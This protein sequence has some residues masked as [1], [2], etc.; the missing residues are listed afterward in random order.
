MKET[1]R[2]T[3]LPKP[4]G[5]YLLTIPSGTNGPV[6]VSNGDPAERAEQVTDLHV[7]NVDESALKSAALQ[8]DFAAVF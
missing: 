2:F 6:V 5:K 7:E 8:E 1:L 3:F 4:D